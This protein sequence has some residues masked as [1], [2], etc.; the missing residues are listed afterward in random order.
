MTTRNL[1]P[2]ADGEGSLGTAE[3]QW[4]AM[5]A[6]KIFVDK[7]FINNVDFGD[8][9]DSAVAASEIASAK[10]IE[11]RS[12]AESAAE[13]TT[14]EGLS[15][16]VLQNTDDI[17]KMNSDWSAELVP[18]AEIQEEKSI[19]KDDA[20][21]GDIVN[22]TTNVNT[23]IFT[24]SGKYDKVKFTIE[25]GRS[26]GVDFFQYDKHDTCFVRAVSYTNNGLQEGTC[27]FV[28][29]RDCHYLKFTIPA[30]NYGQKFTVHAHKYDKT[31]CELPD[32]LSPLFLT[33]ENCVL[34]GYPEYASGRLFFRLT[35]TTRDLSSFNTNGGILTYDKA[36]KVKP[37]TNYALY[38]NR[39]NKNDALYVFC[40]DN[41]GKFISY[42]TLPNNFIFTAPANCEYI[43]FRSATFSAAD[44]ANVNLSTLKI[45]FLEG[46]EVLTPFETFNIKVA[47]TNFANPMD[48]SDYIYPA[49]HQFELDNKQNTYDLGFFTVTDTHTTSDE[50]YR[51]M[52]HFA[53]RKIGD[54][55]LNMGDNIPDHEPNKGTAIDL[56]TR[57]LR[58]S[59][60]KST[61]LPVFNLRGNHDNNPNSTGSSAFDPSLHI[62]DSEY[63][64]IAN[65][66]L[67]EAVV[68]KQSN[69]NYYYVD[70]PSAKI[71]LI[72]LDGGDIYAED[73][74]LLFNAYDVAYLQDQI[75]WFGNVALNFMDKADKAEWAVITTSHCDPI[76]LSQIIN[77]YVLGQS[78]NTTYTYTYPI[79]EDITVNLNADFTTQGAME[80]ITHFSGHT[81]TDNVIDMGLSAG[82]YYRIEVTCAKHGLAANEKIT[83]ISQIAADFVMID[84]TSRKIIMKRIGYGSDREISY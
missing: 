7:I 49:I 75:D 14:P 59:D 26:I 35:Y 34:D 71:R 36:L 80:Y 64:N 65:R 62:H 67:S 12:W 66:G 52:G 2:R 1:V 28:L 39:Y 48:L 51:I 31:S 82:T 16:K 72:C 4:G 18:L 20:A 21:Y 43:R 13:I 57:L 83:N 50:L 78:I 70:F 6:K 46:S 77:A 11:A 40:Y 30:Y 29:A 15:A 37:S 42:I 56:L 23:Y 22:S 60:T 84:R 24:L 10:A 45:A 33:T 54:F 68:H 79:G 17:L 81:H 41:L 55:V 76:C 69:K 27:E 47:T 58:V 63:Y 19:S 5:R 3:K 74:T 8:E 9:V 32:E 61:T 38:S 25:A 44:A 53:V 73:G